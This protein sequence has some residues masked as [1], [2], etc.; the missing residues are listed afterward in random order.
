[1]KTEQEIK[2]KIKILEELRKEYADLGYINSALVCNGKIELLE[3]VINN[4]R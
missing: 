4:D 3:W 1:M 2:D